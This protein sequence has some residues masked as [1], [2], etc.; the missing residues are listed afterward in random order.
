[1]H[2]KS[3]IATTAASIENA[4]ITYSVVKIQVNG[5]KLEYTIISVFDNF[6]I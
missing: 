2:R 5:G 3:S 1:M 4:V 6:D